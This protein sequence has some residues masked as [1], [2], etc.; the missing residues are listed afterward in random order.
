VFLFIYVVRVEIYDI[1][2]DYR[3]FK[4]VEEEGYSVFRDKGLLSPSFVPVKIVSREREE[5]VFARILALGVREGFVPSMVRVYGGPGCGKTVVVRS[6]LERF[7]GYRGDVFRSFYVNLKSCRTVFSSANAVLSEICGRFLPV[8][9]GLDGVFREIWGELRLVGEGGVR[10]VCFVFDEVDSIFLDKHFDPSDFFYRFL[11]YDQYLSGVDVRLMLVVITNNPLMFED[12]LDARVKSSMGN[13]VLIFP[14][15][16]RGEL[17]EILEERSL[18]AF[19]EGVLGDGVV[20][21]CAELVSE[22]SGDARGA[23][24]LL[25]L[26]GE[27]ANE[28]RSNVSK[29]CVLEALDKVGVDWVLELVKGL[30]LSSTVVLSFVAFIASKQDSLSFRELYNVYTSVKYVGNEFTILGERRVA[31]IVKELDT[32]G[33]ISTWNVSRGRRGY[34]KLIKLNVDSKSL[35]DLLTKGVRNL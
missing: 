32:L 35:L 7:M 8:N 13:D 11:R 4:T 25:R 29:E 14:P 16:S 15:Y 34:H 12:N 30:P 1:I 26:S 20:E 18:G 27:V 3:I 9:Y 33:I 28:K 19:K 21:Y 17:M 10:F 6:V 5:G 24:D 23:L 2:L 22:K 31:E